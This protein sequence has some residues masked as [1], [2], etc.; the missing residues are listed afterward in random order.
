MF[1]GR[2]TYRLSTDLQG[3]GHVRGTGRAFAA[4]QVKRLIE[5]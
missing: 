4:A 1:A 2:Y 5:A 3:G